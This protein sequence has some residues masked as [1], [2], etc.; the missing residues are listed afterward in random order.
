MLNSL[1][2]VDATEFKVVTGSYNLRNIP[3]LPKTPC[4]DTSLTNHFASGAAAIDELLASAM[5][6]GESA[7]DEGM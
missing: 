3:A 7:S 5:G 1:P 2:L 6:G 4:S